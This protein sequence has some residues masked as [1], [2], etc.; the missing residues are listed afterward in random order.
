MG[1][2][3]DYYYGKEAEQFSF[4]RIPK[5]LFTDSKF[6]EISC[7]SKI[8]YGLMLDRMGLSIKNDWLDDENRVFIVFTVD[9]V[10]QYMNC[11][12]TKAVKTIK[13][14]SDSNLIER[15]KRG[16]GQ[17]AIIYVKNFASSQSEEESSSRSPKNGLQEVSKMDFKKSKKWT[18][19]SPKN[20]LQEVSKMDSNNTD[21]NNTDLSNNTNTV[22]QEAAQSEKAKKA[23]AN[24]LF[25]K[26]WSIYPNKKG[27]G[28]VSDTA[29]MKL[30]KVGEEEL[31]RALE[32]YQIELEKDAWRKLQNGSTFFNS[33]YI[34][35]LDS[36]YVPTDNKTSIQQK[37]SRNKFH[38]FEQRSY[39]YRALEN[40]FI[41]K[42][43]GVGE[44]AHEKEC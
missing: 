7:E 6:A 37:Q 13:E 19:Q 31:L 25:E 35:Y 26:L 17:P 39:D 33:G 27:K 24:E 28:Q 3:Y 29:K 30:L 4:F 8:L 21:I 1:F 36:N 43:N 32:R 10:M 2:D 38:N 40:R 34:D 23:K 44:F 5:L 9:E 15:K 41:N 22:H 42:T 14:L 12:K 16:L 18:S 11:S 20:G